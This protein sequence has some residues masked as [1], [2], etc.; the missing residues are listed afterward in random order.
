LIISKKGLPVSDSSVE[1]GLHK[2]LGS[3]EGIALIQKIA[4]SV[5]SRLKIYGSA[6]Y[7]HEPAETAVSEI[8]SELTLFVLENRAD[9]QKRL[10]ASGAKKGAYL[11][12]AFINH[13]IDR[14]RSPVADP[15]RYMYKRVR[16]ILNAAPEFHLVVRARKGS[17]FS[18][19]PK[20]RFILPVNDEDLESIPFPHDKIRSADFQSVNTKGAII[21]AATH[22]WR[23]VSKMWDD[24]PV[25]TD[26]RDFVRWLQR[27]VSFAEPA[28][29]SRVDVLE[30]EQA[31]LMAGR[32]GSVDLAESVPDVQ[33]QPDRVYFD[34]ERIKAWAG[35]FA[36]Q[37]SPV[38][39]KIF[40]LRYQAGMSLKEIA[41]KVGYSSPSGPTYQ[42]NQVE[43]KLKFFLMDLPWVSPDGR[44]SPIPEAFDLF[45]N[46]L[47]SFLKKSFGKP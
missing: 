5:Y 26:I 2:W 6:L 37:L 43:E 34:P 4:E 12:T 23:N 46:T 30:T 22:F 14:S 39:A 44:Q 20:N 35:H 17:A 33:T 29:A 25:W 19:H 21:K 45:R 13:L 9:L 10:A 18:M 8:L 27:H 1:N 15:F 47:L 3:S 16:D 41:E 28:S 42:L 40:Y 24:A 38:E 11:Q 36:N 32:G 7:R 31:K